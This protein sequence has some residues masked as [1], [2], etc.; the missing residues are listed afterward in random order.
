MDLEEGYN[1]GDNTNGKGSGGMVW[2]AMGGSAVLAGLIQSMTGF[3]AAVTMMLV[4][5]YF[6]NMLQ[7]PALVTAICLGLS[8]MLVWR[9]RRLVD[10]RHT[11]PLIVLYSLTSM[12]A[13]QVA[14]SLDLRVLTVAFGVFLI[15]LALYY[16]LL[17]NSFTLRPTRLTGVVCSVAAGAGAGLFGTGGPMMAMYFLG[18]VKE[19]EAYVANLQFVFAVTNTVNLVVR[20]YKGIYT[21]DLLPLTIVG[22]IGINLGKLIGLRILDRIDIALMRKIVYIFIGLSGVLTVA[23]QL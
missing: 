23:G 16:L 2:L 14:S 20:L 15:V 7:A 12:T 13:I 22:V 11:L 17:A 21:L 8:V 1:G 10:L 3:G 18:A 19:K 9:F 6:F 5:P 4:A